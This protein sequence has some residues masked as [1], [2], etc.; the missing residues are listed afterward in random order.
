MRTPGGPYGFGGGAMFFKLEG[1]GVAPETA[2]P[3]PAFVFPFVPDVVVVLVVGMLG[4]SATTVAGADGGGSTGAAVVAAGV[5][6][7]G[8]AGASGALAFGAVGFGASSD[9][10]AITAAA[11]PKTTQRPRSTRQMRSARLVLPGSAIDSSDFMLG[12]PTIS[13]GV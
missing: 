5:V 10:T 3:A 7:A 11:V 13:A 4:A 8:D 2:A 1:G 12:R 6:V 9:E